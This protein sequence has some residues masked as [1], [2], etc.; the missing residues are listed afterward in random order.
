VG[1][2][3][4]RRIIS[5]RV[6]RRIVSR[7]FQLKIRSTTHFSNRCDLDLFPILYLSHRDIMRWPYNWLNCKLLLLVSIATGML[8]QFLFSESTPQVVDVNLM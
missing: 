5:S 7:Q 3:I 6:V 4:G 8:A 1:C 2:A